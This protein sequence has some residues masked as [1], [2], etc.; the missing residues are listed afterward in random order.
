MSFS[1]NFV[2]GFS[3]YLTDKTAYLNDKDQ[4]C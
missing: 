1:L 2:S 3:S 4:K